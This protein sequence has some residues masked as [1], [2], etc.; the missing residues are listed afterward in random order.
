[1][2]ILAEAIIVVFVNATADRHIQGGVDAVQK[3]APNSTFRTDGLISAIS[4]MDPESTGNFVD[5]LLEVGMKFVED[6]VAHDIAVVDQHRGPTAQCG[7]L[8]F[9]Q[10]EEGYNIA[11]LIGYPQGGMAVYDNWEPNNDLSFR[12]GHIEETMKFLREENGLDVYL[13]LETGQECF[14]PQSS[15]SKVLEG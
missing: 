15:C 5:T 9:N 12:E 8:G 2:S 14:R 6:G 13:D 3:N 10:T 1:M 4:F 7:W 11:W